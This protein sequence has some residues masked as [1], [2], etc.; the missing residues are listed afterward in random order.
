MGGMSDVLMFEV[1]ANYS[2]VV[3]CTE[4]DHEGCMRGEDNPKAKP[5]I[6]TASPRHHKWRKSWTC[7]NLLLFT[8]K[9]LA[10]QGRWQQNPPAVAYS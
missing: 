4:V 3:V 9:D 6:N 8:T 2:P 1:P 5:R 10:R 7:R